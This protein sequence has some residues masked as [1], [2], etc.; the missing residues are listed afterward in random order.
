MNASNN[1]VHYNRSE[2][3]RFRSIG[4]WLE[5]PADLQAELKGHEQA[6]VIVVGA[7]FAGLSTA[8]ELNALGA[9]VIV[10]EQEFAGFG[11]SGRNAGYLLG[12]MAIEFDLF[13]KR[14][15]L[16]K[17]REFVSFYD[18]A[19]T[20]VEGRLTALGIHCDYTPSGVIRAAVHPSQEKRLRAN[21]ELGHKLGS[22]TRFVDP[23]EMRARGIPPAFLFGSAQRGGTLNPGKYI[24]GLRRAALSA[25]VKLYERTPLLSYS[26][27]SAITCKTPHGSATA[28]VMVLATNAYTPQLGLLRNKVA[29]IRVSAIETQRLSE[30]QL[31]SLGWKGREGLITP[32]YTMESH[33]LTAHDTMVLTVKQLG[34]VYGSKTPNVP[35]N[36]AYAALVRG[37]RERFPSLQNLGIQ[38]CWSGYVS[39]AYDAL[40]VV[41]STGV[42]QNIFYSVGCSGHGLATQSLMGAVLAARIAGNDPSRLAA[43]ERQ[44][45]SMLPEPFQWCAIKAAF[46]V[47][48]LLDERIDNKVR[49]ERAFNG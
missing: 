35:D 47:A 4:G 24:N 20:Y 22:V 28:P 30:E 5:R 2:P 36:Q 10:L 48:K 38:H 14:V 17:A 45:P 25:G 37:L 40:P 7:G 19:V 18:E 33:R 11:A 44:V 29:P 43:L 8:L 13:V 46:A 42:K 23:V 26:E 32:H 39:A 12:S 9:K 41:G 27:G 31:A 16:K 15:G 3:L 21:M 49:K 6:D 34:Y 1:A